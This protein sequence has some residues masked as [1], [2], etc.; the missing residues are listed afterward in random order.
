MKSCKRKGI[1]WR[2]GSIEEEEKEIGKS[3]GHR[4]R[5]LDLFLEL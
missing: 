4:L 2:Q 1:K 3:H 5:L